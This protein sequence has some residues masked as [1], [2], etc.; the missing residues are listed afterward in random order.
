MSKFVNL[1]SKYRKYTSNESRLLDDDGNLD[2]QQ[3]QL[4]NLG[5]P[6]PENDTLNF[7]NVKIISNNFKCDV[8]NQQILTNQYLSGDTNRLTK[9]YQA[10]NNMLNSFNAEGLFV[11]NTLKLRKE[12]V[13]VENRR[14]EK[15]ANPE[16]GA[17]VVNFS[18]FDDLKK[19][20]KK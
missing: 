9:I 3:K 6:K 7:Q 12:E 5:D 4:I 10:P 19:K 18:T 16:N 2:L 13:N 8:V 20:L 1:G 15:V 14:V 17:G 11:K